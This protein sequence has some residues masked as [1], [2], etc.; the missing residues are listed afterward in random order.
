MVAGILRG[1]KIELDTMKKK[2]SVK[3]KITNVD[4]I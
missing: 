2:E 1:A 4:M 3:I